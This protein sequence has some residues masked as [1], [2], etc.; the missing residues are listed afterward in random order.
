MLMESGSKNRKMFYI[1]SLKNYSAANAK[2]WV[3][4]MMPESNTNFHRLLPKTHV[5]AAVLAWQIITGWALLPAIAQP[6]NEVSNPAA[7][8]LPAVDWS[9]ALRL[10]RVIEGWVRN[11]G[12]NQD[13]PELA[14][15]VTGALGVRVTL[16]WSGVT[17]GLGDGLSQPTC[18][19]QDKADHALDSPID[20]IPLARLATH[21]AL[22][23]V[24]EKLIAMHGR[25][26]SAGTAAAGSQPTSLKTGRSAIAGGLANRPQTPA[27]CS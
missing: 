26:L 8:F 9:D 27:D 15:R 21:D 22:R 7:A 19:G 4:L 17:M 12:S 16:R 14:I 23:A 11:G 25:A 20:L 24:N 6:Q 18:G 13:S 1:N 5:L 3:P 10:H 2:S